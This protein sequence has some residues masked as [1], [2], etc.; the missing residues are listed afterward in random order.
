MIHQDPKIIPEE[1]SRDPE[2]VGRR[3]DKRLTD[4][5]HDDGDR[6]RIRLWK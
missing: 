1:R 6:G 4:G 5:K 3:D 2:R